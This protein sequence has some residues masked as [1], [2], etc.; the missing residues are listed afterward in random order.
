MEECWWPNPHLSG[1]NNSICSLMVEWSGD[2]R[3]YRRDTKSHK[4]CDELHSRTGVEARC[5][6]LCGRKLCPLSKQRRWEV[7]LTP[8]LVQR[9]P[10]GLPLTSAEQV[11]A[12][13]WAE[14]LEVRTLQSGEGGSLSQ[15]YA[16]AAFPRAKEEVTRR[17]P[18]AA[19]LFDKFSLHTGTG[20]G[21]GG[22]VLQHRNSHGSVSAGQGVPHASLSLG[23]TVQTFLPMKNIGLHNYPYVA[24]KVAKKFP[25]TTDCVSSG[26]VFSA[27]HASNS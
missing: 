2:T 25:P 8:S 4:S 22:T 21:D 24:A 12:E 27:S 3:Q 1:V 9:S 13:V 15:I 16:N 6:C 18:G 5:R 11:D 20:A 14:Q 26:L 17:F 19:L 23:Y 10:R 7:Q